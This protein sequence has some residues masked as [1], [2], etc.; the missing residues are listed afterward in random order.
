M[1]IVGGQESE[2]D[3]REMVERWRDGRSGKSMVAVVGAAD[4][5]DGCRVED[6]RLAVGSRAAKPIHP[7]YWDKDTCTSTAAANIV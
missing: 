2:R 4:D 5:A 3:S 7:L 1:S 6:R